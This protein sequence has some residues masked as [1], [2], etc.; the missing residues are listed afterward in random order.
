M[1]KSENVR[2]NSIQSGFLSADT[3]A[4]SHRKRVSQLVNTLSH[5]MNG[6]IHTK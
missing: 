4:Y 3:E 1:D 5:R 2:E 6:E